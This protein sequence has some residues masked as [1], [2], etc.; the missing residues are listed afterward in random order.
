MLT[1]GRINEQKKRYFEISECRQVISTSGYEYERLLLGLRIDLQE[2][3]ES[4]EICR[5]LEQKLT[6]FE[7]WKVNSFAIHQ[8]IEA[9][10]SRIQT[11]R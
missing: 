3:P 5:L 9:E 6:E 11:K 7:N 2:D 10:F 8:A 1:E 4:E